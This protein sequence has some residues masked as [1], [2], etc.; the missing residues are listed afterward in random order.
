[1]TFTTRKPVRV[2]D[3]RKLVRLIKDISLEGLKE[4][5]DK[6]RFVEPVE[7]L[8]GDLIRFKRASQVIKGA[9]VSSSQE[10]KD[11]LFEEAAVSF[12]LEKCKNRYW[13]SFLMGQLE[14]T[15]FPVTVL[16]LARAQARAKLAL[17]EKR[18]GFNWI[19]PGELIYSLKGL[20]PGFVFELWEKGLLIA[21][22][23]T[24]SDGFGIIINPLLLAD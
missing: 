9:E 19:T 13:L 1:M 7:L 8:E 12:L 17:E 18:Y 15:V 5:S 3:D 20:P 10:V 21:H 22:Q 6:K 2:I 16:A 24:V 14:T 4:L 23:D 11:W